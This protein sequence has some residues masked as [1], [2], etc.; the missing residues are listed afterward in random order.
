[1]KE[2]KHIDRL[3]QEGFKDFEAVPNDAVWLRIE[4]KL[5]QNIKKRRVIPIWWRYAGI[6][7]LLLLLLSI[8][9]LSLNS[10][11]FIP[12]NQTVK[13]TESSPEALIKGN[14][15]INANNIV[16]S[17]TTEKEKSLEN[18][19]TLSLENKV[20]LN[21]L[22]VENSSAS[23][24]NEFERN[25]LSE[26]KQN[27]KTALYS[28]KLNTIV[29]NSEEN[30]TNTITN[31]QTINNNTSINPQN[32]SVFVVENTNKN[33]SL[34]DS[35]ITKET[36]IDEVI[37]QTN[38]ETIE[39]DLSKWTIATNAAP[40]YFNSLGKGSSL[41]AQFNDNSKNGEVTMSYGITASYAINNK[42]SIRS[43]VNKVNLGY[44]TSNVVVFETIG[45]RSNSSTLK[46][47]NTNNATGNVALI[48]GESLIDLINEPLME[49]SNT[50]V[51]QSL[52]FIEIPL[53]FEYALI[54]KKFGFN[55]IGG[56]SS[57]ILNS[58]ELFSELNGNRTRIGEATNL[59]KVSYSANLGLG[60][61]YKITKK[62][63]LNLEPLFKYQINTFN[64][65][66]GNFKPYFIGVYTGVGFKF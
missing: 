46:N 27:I 28:N 41:D 33:E 23:K 57:F 31:G 26:D 61:N 35:S 37:A 56:F 63:D 9:R 59:N 13:T 25:I 10:G 47:V 22:T 58:N 19:N 34:F 36:S 18:D 50:S 1:M 14:N 51:N 2:K 66:S 44:N 30:K 3:F 52:G 62:L 17:N 8:G 11:D 4:A 6:A 42:L 40:V 65:T 48:S 24:E 54:N 49:T 15:I 5:N 16:D 21:K 53:E 43:G 45:L 29:D 39:N 38:K 7:A 60:L 32:T 64:N 55:I 12:E 20:G